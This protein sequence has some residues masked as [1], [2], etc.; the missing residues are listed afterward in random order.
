MTAI[1]K[2]LRDFIAVIGL[3]LISLVV[4]WILVQQERLRV[5]VLEEKPFELKAELSTA[6][7]VAPGQ[8][9]TVRVAG[10]RV[11]DIDKVELKN[12]V[13]VVT[14]AIDRKFVPI[15]RN[16]TL[17]LRPKTG[18]K[19][20]FLELDP[21]S[22][23]AGEFHEGD[24]ISVANT[25]PDIDLDQ[26]LA[27]LDS[28]TQAYLRLLLT[29]AGQGLKGQGQNLGKLLGSLGPINRQLSRLNGE[30]AKRRHNLAH[31]IHNFRLLTGA[32]GK[33]D[34]T[35]AQLVD[36]SNA[37][38][39]A[40]A[41]E[42]PNVQLAVA[43]LPGTLKTTTATLNK[44]NTFA[45]VA[46]PTFNNLRPFARNLDEMNASVRRLAIS[47]TP[48]LRNKI[49]P[50]VRS[51]R[52]PINDLVAAAGPLARAT[53]Q[54]TVIAHKI[55]RLGNMAAYNPRGAEPPSA[56]PDVQSTP[57]RDEGY[58][59][60]LAY[61]AHNGNSVFQTQDAHGAYRRIYMTASCHS[62][63]SILANPLN[64]I[65]T[66]LGLL[67]GTVPGFPSTPTMPCP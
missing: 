36:A 53:P 17:L 54:L 37:D 29:G 28:D 30:V 13:A 66:P 19:D 6:Q 44:V 58:L 60:W 55:N 40:I 62:A 41:S 23:S 38:F 18:L 65:T 16:A 34:K 14:L 49:R 63:E 3:L 31:L 39:Q 46:G 22:R 9:Q 56:T 32:V 52:R 7:A 21:G 4:G 57:P 25:L 45:Q 2:H 43:R 64:A 42:D 50:F 51:A 48:V 12:G 24:T 27:A 8:G 20:M 1:R 67:F 33:K 61:L 5:P 26:V 10:V 11:G 35:I 59:Y 47:A 15:Y